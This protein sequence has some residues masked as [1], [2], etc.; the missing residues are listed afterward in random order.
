MKR[1]R[2]GMTRPWWGAATIPLLLLTHQVAGAADA[3]PDTI[4]I[5]TVVVTAQKRVEP[6]Q[7]TP[8]S[9]TAFDAS[10]LK[11]SNMLKPTDIVAQIPNASFSSFFGEGQNP[12]FC[13]RSICLSGQFG[14]GFEPPVALYTDEVYT[15]SAFG[16][17]LQ[18]F[19]VQRIEV[20]KGPQGTLY[21]RNTTGGL[22][23]IILNKPTRD[24]EASLSGEYGSYDNMVFEGVVSG[25]ITD[26]IQ[27]RLSFQTHNRNG[28][29][30][31]LV[32]GLKSNDVNTQAVRGMLN[33]DLSG[34]A[35]LLL[36]A[37]YFH[38]DQGG[39]AYGIYGTVDPDGGVCS[40]SKRIRGNC[41]GLFGDNSMTTNGWVGSSAP[42]KW[43]GADI[44]TGAKPRNFIENYSL[45]ATLNWDLGGDL[46]LTSISSYNIGHK[47]TVE[48]LDGPL[49]YGYD[50]ELWA[51]TKT[52]SQEIRLSGKSYFD[53]DW[54]AGVFVYNDS[55]HLG[56]NLFP[57]TDYEDHST[58]N[59]T[60][61]ALYANAD[62]PLPHDLTLTVGARYS[63]EEMGV[64]FNRSGDYVS[65]K[66][67]ERRSNTDGDIDGKAVLKWS[68]ADDTMF[69]ASFT[70]GY[71]SASVITQYVWGAVSK[72]AAN[73][74]LQPTKPEKLL[75]YEVGSKTDLIGNRLRLNTAL[76]FYDF[77]NKQ[78][79]LRKLDCDAKQYCTSYA[80]MSNIKQSYVWGGE[81]SLEAAITADLFA[82]ASFGI[83]DSK[84][85]SHENDKNGL[86]LNGSKLPMSAPTANFGV[87]YAL[88]FPDYIGALKL[89]ANY[90]W[91]GGHSFSGGNDPSYMAYEKSYGLT[92]V[93]LGWYLPSAPFRVDVFA[94]NLGNVKYYVDSQELATTTENVVWGMPRTFGIRLTYTN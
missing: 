76:F 22:F 7:Q 13:F 78:L 79:S 46:N 37:N 25:P 32:D 75:A 56:T 2:G 44:S 38:V 19:D 72:G 71:R 36:S 70:S 85:S 34:K 43:I 92:D 67:N 83:T 33:F 3:N 66:T 82:D 49:Q 28:W 84:I 14:D 59:T 5:E 18:F 40:V 61:W 4:Q 51:R 12:S 48:D 20:L 16:Q 68:P 29:V 47:Q 35:S 31:G 88:P 57:I 80:V 62:I 63:W 94:K 60:S 58:K 55:R 10:A 41:S 39:Q 17:S 23:N 69:Y 90:D 53:I 50:D 27:G 93:N 26:R 45:N 91:I 8:L 81:V 15:S 24:F 64:V 73:D 30:D 54:L 21:G 74:S 87:T 11:T 1:F 9:I 86:P 77:R 42:D 89:R 65:A 6:V 52:A